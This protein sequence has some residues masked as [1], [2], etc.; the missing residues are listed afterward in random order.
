M[1]ELLEMLDKLI[2]KEN[3]LPE[4]MFDIEEIF[5]VPKTEA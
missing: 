3:Y 1:L 4:Q 5:P 2:V